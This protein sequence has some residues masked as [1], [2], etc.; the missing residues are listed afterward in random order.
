MNRELFIQAVTK[1]SAGLLIVGLL[2]FLPA[3][4]L[5]YPQGWLLLGI[6]FIP[7]FIAGLVMMKKNPELLK[8]RL[9]AKEK[10]IWNSAASD[11]YGNSLF[12]PRHASGAEIC[13]FVRDHALLHSDHRKA[14]QE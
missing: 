14:D 9:N 11:V 13:L 12:V 4:T 5:R 6:L 1:F 10:E 8:K 3:G 2:L 7:M